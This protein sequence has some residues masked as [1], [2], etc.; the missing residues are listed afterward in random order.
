MADGATLRELP[1]ALLLNLR[2][3]AGANAFGSAVA[4]V[5]GVTPAV[6]PNTAAT[7]GDIGL[8][9][10]GPDEWL[11]TAP[12]EKGELVERLE[13]ALAGMHHSLI[14]VSHGRVALELDG[15]QARTVLAQGT[16]L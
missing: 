3:K 6:E 2:G 16:S 9:W 1:P 10:L 4:G 12:T 8:L 15:P 14:D 11:V 13:A 7:S 5:L